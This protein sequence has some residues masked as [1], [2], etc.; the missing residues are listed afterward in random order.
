MS[1]EFVLNLLLLFAVNLLIKPL[2]AFG[3]DMQV[4]NAAGNAAYGLYFAL[5]SF[6]C[7]F[8]MLGDMGI[9][10]YQ[11]REVAANGGF[12][13]AQTGALLRLKLLLTAFM[14]SAALLVAWWSGYG[15][16]ELYCL[17]LLLVNQTLISLT[18]FFRAS[19]SGLG[20]YRLDSLLS[21][22]DKFLLL[23]F[24][25]LLL[26][27]ESQP[28]IVQF[29]YVQMLAFGLAALV[30]GSVV[31]FFW[32]RGRSKNAENIA[33]MRTVA[34]LRAG[35]PYAVAVVLMMIYGRLDGVLMER[36]I[37]G[38]LGRSMSG[39]YAFAFRFWDMGNMAG[40]L[41]S[42]LLLP[43]YAR[44]LEELEGLRR[45]LLLASS[46]LLFLTFGLALGV[47]IFAEDI[48]AWARPNQGQ[49]EGIALAFR[50]LMWSLV[51][52]ALVHVWGT[53]LTAKG[54][55][56]RVNRLFVGAIVLNIGLNLFFLPTWGA[57]GAALSALCTQ[58]LVGL[59]EVF[60]VAKRLQIHPNLRTLRWLL[61]VGGAVVSAFAAEGLR[62]WA[63]G[64]WLLEGL[65]WGLIY[66]LWS[67]L[68]GIVPL[69][70]LRGLR[71]K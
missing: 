12:F 48:L 30:S 58:V 21:A 51:A 3:V 32:L 2:Y 52:G 60:W 36:Y 31:A 64:A 38:D 46:L 33:P 14:W 50:L 35:L 37:G 43:M 61:W 27:I 40:V 16:A 49:T 47:G 70:G 22:L 28:S 6:S 42:G 23:L 55:L 9:Q 19:V 5:W 25:F 15:G 65:V 54:E 66:A 41:V 62:G 67:L 59:V 68:L 53:W 63:G 56:W 44:L 4:Q 11:N 20:W 26:R 29:I 8:Q 45:L 34:L 71:K 69:R 7:L 10:Q 13:Y 39:D 1:K 57:A 24:G 18:L 17:C